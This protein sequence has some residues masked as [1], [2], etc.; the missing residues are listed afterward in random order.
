MLVLSFDESK[1]QI[2]RL[3]VSSVGYSGEVAELGL[4]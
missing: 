1:G 3:L 2:S 4:L